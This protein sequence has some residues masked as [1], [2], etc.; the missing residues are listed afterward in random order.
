[1]ASRQALARPALLIVRFLQ[2]ASTV[3][4]LGITSYFINRGPRGGHII[5]QEVIVRAEKKLFP[6]PRNDTNLM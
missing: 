3:I 4:V 6:F 1:M 5:Y 2:W